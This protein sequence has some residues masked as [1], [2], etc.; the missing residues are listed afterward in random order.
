MHNYTVY[1]FLFMTG[2]AQHRPAED[3]RRHRPSLPHSRRSDEDFSQSVP[4]LRSVQGQ[5]QLVRLHK[6]GHPLPAAHLA[7]GSSR[8]AGGR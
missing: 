5:P 6:Y 7:A 8:L 1:D 4:H 3:V 2:C